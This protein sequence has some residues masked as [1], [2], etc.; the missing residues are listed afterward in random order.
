MSDPAFDR[1]ATARS[2]ADAVLYEG[3]VLYPYRASSRKNQVRFQWGVL[4]PRQF[5][6]AEGSERWSMRTECLVEPGAGTGVDDEAEPVI[7]VRIRCLQAQH[8]SIEGVTDTDGGGFA[9]VDYLEIDGT[10]HV[11]W[12]EAVDQV[13]DVAPVSLSGGDHIEVFSFPGSIDTETITSADGAVVG[14]FVRQRE[15]IEGE[16]RITFGRPDAALPYRTVS[17]AVENT[18]AW[19]GSG[20]HRDDAM[21]RS[22][23]A[24]HTM[25]AVDGGRFISLLDPPPEA[26]SVVSAC[27]SDG[28]Y[29]V[30]IGADDVVLASPIILYDHPE[31]AEQSPGDLYDSLEIDEILALR[32]MTLTDEEK[33][34]ARGTDARAAAIIDRCDEMTAETLSR[35]H[36]QMKPVTPFASEPFASESFASE[37]FASESFDFDEIPQFGAM[38]GAEPPWWDPEVDAS[39]DPWTESVWVAGVEITKGSPVRLR[40]SHRADAHDIFLKG[41]AATVAG[42]FSDVDGDQHIAVTVDDDPATQEL[43]WQGRFL[44]FHPDEVEPLVDQDQAR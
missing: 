22:L 20:L 26:E 4:T 30:L 1:F 16:V 36:G 31:V 35:L 41:M 13:V 43:L 33:S 19:T 23:I 25:L 8:R 2:V 40:P 18:T 39:Y 27:R 29:P 42:V 17:V 21:S 44:F 28:S 5:A 7:S 6:E 24:V 15:P 14:R 10:L 12:D 37:S 38:P 9:P 34:E 3:Y 32:V 11:D